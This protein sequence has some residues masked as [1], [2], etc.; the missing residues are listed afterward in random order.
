LFINR[1]LKKTTVHENR[2]TEDNF[3]PESTHGILNRR[4]FFVFRNL[5]YSKQLK[6]LQLKLSRSTIAIYPYEKLLTVSQESS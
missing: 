1:F 3:A 5:F 2:K 4:Q 6:K